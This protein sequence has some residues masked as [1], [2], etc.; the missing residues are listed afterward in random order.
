VQISGLEHR[1][2]LASSV[3]A[4]QPISCRYL[5]LNTAP[6]WRAAWW[7]SSRFRADIWS[8]TP[9]HAG[10]QRG[11]EAADLVQISGLEHRSTL[12]S[13]VVA[14]RRR[15]PP[16]VGV[17]C[18]LLVSWCLGLLPGC[19]KKPKWPFLSCPC[20]WGLHARGKLFRRPLPRSVMAA[21]TR[22]QLF[23]EGGKHLSGPALAAA[24]G[25]T[26]RTIPDRAGLPAADAKSRR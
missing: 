23:L 10:K 26:P 7:R 3:V 11:G 22:R 19:A 2:T 24:S 6:R 8:R 4:K 18:T 9:L 20:V 13:S 15:Y 14:K 5:V 1:S 25:P 21:L 12:A 17:D 16:N